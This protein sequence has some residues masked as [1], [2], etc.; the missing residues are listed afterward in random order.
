M[1]DAMNLV[2]TEAIVLRS[3]NLAEADRIVLCF[4]RSAGLIRGVAKGARR[5]K[6][7][8]GAALEPFTVI[9]LE[10]REKENRELVTISGA[11]IVKSHFDLAADIEVAEV[12]G[13]MAELIGEFAPPHEAN[14]KLFRMVAACVDAL[15]TAP[16]TSKVILR[17]FEIWLLR[18]AGS[19]P[20]VSACTIC[21][22][23]L[24]QGQ[25]MY[26]D[27]ESAVRCATCS[28]G[29]GVLL[30]PQVQQVL[31]SSLQLGPAEFA[32][33]CEPFFTD[34][35]AELSEFTHRLIVRTLERRPRTLTAARA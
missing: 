23:P 7:R 19:F 24:N 20:D 25:A 35:D 15:A 34:A 26:L 10:F 16:S 5:M 29:V 18:L 3:Y 32:K 28:R 11:E 8:F 6:S 2:T 22:A 33:T 14:D 31:L 4:T 27:F 1:D 9:R 12:L 21:G 30:M 13:Y 17:Y